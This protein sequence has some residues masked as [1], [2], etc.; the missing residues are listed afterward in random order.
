MVSNTIVRKGVWVRIPHPALLDCRSRPPQ[1]LCM[2]HIRADAVVA[3]ALVESDAGLSDAA[4]A[5]RHGVAVKT[6]RRWRRD[7]QRLGKPRGQAHTR[8]PCPR[9]TG[10]DLA[11]APYVELLGW[12][13]GDGHLTMTRSGVLESA[14]LQRSAVPAGQCAPDRHHASGEARRQTTHSIAERMSLSQR[15]TGSTGSACSLSTDR[16]GSTSGS[17][18][19]SPGNG[20]SSRRSR[21]RSCAACSTPTA[22]GATTGRPAG[23]GGDQAL[24]VPALGVQQPL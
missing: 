8:V 5:A 3:S 9:C 20:S 13:L 11:A 2:V 4:N 14:H 12:Y 16:V 6:I 1:S 22:R 19:C 24:R 15:W 10:A 21:R 18:A 7:Y 23:R 17:S